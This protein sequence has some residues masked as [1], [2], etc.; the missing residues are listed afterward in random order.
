MTDS[1]YVYL[2]VDP[3]TKKPMYVGK[4]KNQR[5]LHHIKSVVK[6]PIPES[7]KMFFNTLRNRLKQGFGHPSIL[8]IH[9]DVTEDVAFNE[10]K[11]LIKKIGRKDLNTGPLL[12]LTN[13]GDG[14][15]ISP[16]IV[17]KSHNTR[18]YI[19][20]AKKRTTQHWATISDEKNKAR[21]K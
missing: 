5:Y 15:A 16:E 10:E 21:C 6:Q 7:G 20:E 14:G 19:K 4:G 12:N 9:N 11:R 18:K 8:I 17:K 2:Y 1:Y 3:K 13:G